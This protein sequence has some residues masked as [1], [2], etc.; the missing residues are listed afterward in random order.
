[1][2][3][4]QGLLVHAAWYHYHWETYHTHH[5]M[6]LQMASM[7]VGDLGLDRQESFSMQHIPRDGKEPRQAKESTTQTAAGKRALLGCYYLC[8]KSSLFCRQLHMRHT[9][10]IDQCAE[11]L[12][13]RAEYPTD[14]KLKAYIDAQSRMSQSQLLFDEK[15]QRG[16][17]Q[18]PVDWDRVL[19][20]TAQQREHTD[21]LL[22]S[23]EAHDWP[24]SLEV[25]AAPALLL[26]QSLRRQSHVFKLQELNQLE[27]M[28]TS[29][30]QT[31]DTFLKMPSA[32]ALHLTSAAYATIW[33]CLLA[34]SKL[35][36]LFRP[37][38]LL[39]MGM[40]RAKVH[41]NGVAI[42]RKFETLSSK[43]GFWTSSKRVVGSMLAWLE[44]SSSDSQRPQTA[45]AGS[46]QHQDAGTVPSTEAVPENDGTMDVQT[47]ADDDIDFGVWDQMLDSFTW[48]GSG[49]DN[50]LNFGNFGL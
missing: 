17:W 33:F 27:F 6:L 38:E 34:I 36:L 20:L 7:V 18:I 9:S 22:S 29:A 15:R 47:Q 28:T 19:K 30:Q 5:Y 43:E 35:S 11:Y 45:E 31:I 39:S 23:F 42:I 25:G 3:I 32:T 26:G 50:H 14:L 8:S 12:T 21:S 44:K 37:H 2:D 16:D 49:V 46:A 41:E 48:F 1:M 13:E 4:L 40:D 24:L 10:W